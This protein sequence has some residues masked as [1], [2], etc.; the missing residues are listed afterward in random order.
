MRA[1]LYLRL[2][3]QDDASTGIA[4]QEADLRARAEREG[5]T[6]ARVLVDDGISGRR[7]RAN[8]DAALAMLTDREAD[9]LAVWKFDRWSRQGLGALA[10][11]VE[12]LDE[13]PGALF[14]ADRDGL[15]SSQPAWRIIASV[16][17]EVARMEAE[18]TSARVSSSIA[19]LRSDRRFAGGTVPFGYT[20][21]PN[22]DGPGR[23]LVVHEAEAAVLREAIDRA[24]SGEPLWTVCRDFNARGIPAPRSPY[25]RLERAGEPLDEADTGVWRVQS[26]TRTLTSSHL[27][28]R[29]T[30]RGELLR[31]ES[32]LP[33]TVWEPLT[34]SE[35]LSRLRS[36]LLPPEA[37]S[38]P[39]RRRSRPLSGLIRCS[40]CGSPLYVRTSNGYPLYGCPS[41]VNGALCPSPR[42]QARSLESYVI[43]EARSRLSD[44]RLSE[45]VVVAGDPSALL[46][47][48]EALRHASAALLQDGADVPA[49]VARIDT[50]KTRRASLRESTGPRTLHAL[51]EGPLWCDAFDEATSDDRRRDLL[52]VAIDEVRISPALRRTNTLDPARVEILWRQ[53]LA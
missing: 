17:A 53:D 35:T 49:L 1:V 24:L 11:L 43:A 42:I 27:L 22:P 13:R 9:V 46:D 28:G 23:V 21:A 19:A 10:R 25:R 37:P 12:V 4:R 32:G 44:F 20:T 7:S 30:H 15:V 5:W 6:V 38:R 8:A 51:R 41:S 33:L 16:L 29:V 39:R 18:N 47:V 48:E 14:V 52:G 50:L 26:L 40:V 31:G 34:S 2:S 36:L 45:T 3:E